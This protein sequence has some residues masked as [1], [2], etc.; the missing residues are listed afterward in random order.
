[1][2]LLH[3]ADWQLG[4][5]RHYLAGEAQARFSGD[6]IEAVRAMLRLAAEERCDAVVVAGDVFESNHVDR[7]TVVQALD[8][9]SAAPVTIY[10]LPGNHDPLDAASVWR[11]RTFVERKPVH[12]HVLDSTE[13]CAL[14]AGGEIV[15]VPWTSRRPLQDLVA[16][17]CAT[18]APA[19]VPRV[20]VAHGCV[21]SLSPAPSDPAVIGLAAAEQA[22]TERKLQ[23]LALGDRHSLTEVGAS[24]RICYAGTPEPTDFDEGEP[25]S[26]LVLDVDAAGGLTATPHRIARWTFV[27]EDFDLVCEDDLGR[28]ATWLTSFPDKPRTVVK[29]GLRGTLTL[30][31]RARL[32]ATLEQ[33]RD[34]LAAVALSRSRSDLALRPDDLEL[35]GLDLSGFALRAAEGLRAR[36]TAGGADV[37]AARGALDLLF[38]LARREETAL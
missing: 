4:M 31:Q 30:A 29:L 3:T 13:P 6:R 7:R 16:A 9:M 23:Y 2:R 34:L 8:A 25:G 14:P 22:L 36:A 17:A 33:A 1:M 28:L 26:V 24:G 21:D 5:T 18:L 20:V 15:G 35:S 27:R 37:E 38:R 32:D 10:L 19:T 12:V 11:S